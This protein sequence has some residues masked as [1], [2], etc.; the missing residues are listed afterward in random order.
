MQVYGASKLYNIMIAEALNE[1][2]KGTG[3]EAFSAHPGE[4]QSLPSKFLTIET[5]SQPSF[6]SWIP[7]AWSST[8]GFWVAQCSYGCSD[9]II[10]LAHCQQTCFE[11]LSDMLAHFLASLRPRMFC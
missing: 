2:L 11:G 3:V 8:S 10:Y 9:G 5:C 7:S 4:L 6:S 1:K